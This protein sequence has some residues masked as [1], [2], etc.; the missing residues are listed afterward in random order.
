[1]KKSLQIQPFK[2]YLCHWYFIYMKFWLHT[3]IIMLTCRRKCVITVQ[4]KYPI[5]C[6]SI[7]LQVPMQIIITPA[8]KHAFQNT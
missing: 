1:M 7:I 2:H 4:R 8:Q 3:T 5:T 6:K